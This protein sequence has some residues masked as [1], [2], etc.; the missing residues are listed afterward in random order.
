MTLVLQSYHAKFSLLVRWVL[1][2]VWFSGFLLGIFFFFRT[3]PYCVSLMR[4]LSIS[5]VS[6]V[7][8][9]FCI[10]LPFLIS[11]FAVYYSRTLIV[12]AVCFFKTFCYMVV[13][14]MILSSYNGAGWLYCQLLMV[15]EILS[16]P[17]LY[18]FVYRCFRLGRLPGGSEL[19]GWLIG[20]VLLMIFSVQVMDPI[21][22][23]L[24]IL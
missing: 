23:V 5:S 21:L 15:H 2:C 6:I 12:F 3:V 8:V 19:V 9:M 22:R 7:G 4:G 10:L 24:D 17:I 16:L 1:A 11:A 14:C 20:H 13:S 18:C